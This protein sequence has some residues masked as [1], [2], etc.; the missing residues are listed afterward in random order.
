MQSNEQSGLWGTMSYMAPEY[1]HGDNKSPG[2][3]VYSFGVVLLELVSGASVTDKNQN[4]EKLV[5]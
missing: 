2:L 4:I 3:D 5:S 1:Y